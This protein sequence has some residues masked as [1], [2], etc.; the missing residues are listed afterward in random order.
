MFDLALLFK[1]GIVIL[2]FSLGWGL[3]Y[4]APKL[5]AN[6][7]IEEVSEEVVKDETGIDIDFVGLDP[8]N[9]KKK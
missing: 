9:E 2:V 7:V 4:I 6:K 3:R 1:V 8:N 5:T